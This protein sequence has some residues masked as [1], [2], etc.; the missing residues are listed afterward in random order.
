MR[1]LL[2]FWAL[3][4]GL[5]WGWYGLS[6]HD[7]NFGLGF[8]SREMNDLLFRLYGDILGI[9][10]ETIPP[11]VAR[12]CVVDS[13]LLLGI[14]AFRRRKAIRAWLKEKRAAYA[15]EKAVQPSAPNLSS[16]P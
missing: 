5:F 4:M 16:A 10:P 7:I 11:L 6:Y 14:V 2:L 9:E 8:F 3:P 13:F 12:A 1:Y 15:G